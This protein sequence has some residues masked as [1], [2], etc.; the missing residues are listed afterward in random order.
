MKLAIIGSR[1]ASDIDI[2]TYIPRGCTEIVS[3]GARGI[4]QCAKNTAEVLG[5]KLTEFIPDY[6]R[7]KKGTPLMRNKQIVE[8]S[9]EVLAFWNGVSVGTKYT[10]DYCEKTGKKC[11][12]IYI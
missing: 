8:Y 6:K 7:Y 11:T 1:D 2:S 10:I 5:L 9:D 4:D 3:G 12:V